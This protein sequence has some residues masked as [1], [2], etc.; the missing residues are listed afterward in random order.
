[1]AHAVEFRKFTPRNT[2]QD[3]IEKLESAPQEHVEAILSA[4]ELL[5]R[6]HDKGLI[7][8]AKGLLSASDTV[9]D[10]AV[11]VISSKQ[12]VTATRVGLLLMNLLETLD[13]EKMHNLLTPAKPKSIS[14]GS[15]AKQIFSADFWRGIAAGVGLL[16]AFG[17]ALSKKPAQP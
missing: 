5:Q 13:I 9:I 17:G 14:V 15:V 7:D 6:L 3:L 16:N 8:V 1:M 12:A 10:R 4:Y 11:A 2:R